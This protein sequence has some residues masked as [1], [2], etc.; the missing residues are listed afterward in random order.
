M[1]GCICGERGCGVHEVGIAS[2]NCR[3]LWASFGPVGDDHDKPLRIGDV[4][5]PD[6]AYVLAPG[7][8]I[9]G[10]RVV[11]ICAGVPGRPIALETGA[12]VAGL[13]VWY[14]AWQ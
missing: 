5:G 14:G 13:D 8:V 12:D 9:I 7:T 2:D 1:S 3:A 11:S 10:A 6:S 4:I